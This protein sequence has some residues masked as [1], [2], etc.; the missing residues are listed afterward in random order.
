MNVYERS[1][2]NPYIVLGYNEII[3]YV[4]QTNIIANC[5]S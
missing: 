4:L 1:K 3:A 5:I 2:K